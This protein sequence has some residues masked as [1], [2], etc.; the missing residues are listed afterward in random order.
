MW[1]INMK[2]VKR[3]EDGYEQATKKDWWTWNLGHQ[4]ERRDWGFEISS[5]KGTSEDEEVI[6]MNLYPFQSI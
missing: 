1:Y 5:K 6:R 3:C 2:I 4:E